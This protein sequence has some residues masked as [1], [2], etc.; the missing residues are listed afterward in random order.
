MYLDSFGRV[1]SLA[2]T[3]A[4]K[5]KHFTD[6]RRQIGALQMD[7]AEKARRVDTLQYQ[8]EELRRAK[9]TPGEEEELTARRGD[10]PERGEVPGRGG[11]GG[12]CP[13][14]RRQRRRGAQ[15]SAAGPGRA[16]WRT[17]SG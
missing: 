10:A 16:E 8:I 1:E 4:E 7:E 12:L 11:R 3:Y 2:I 17:T 14:R 6:I 13:E 5:Y 15:R 9:L